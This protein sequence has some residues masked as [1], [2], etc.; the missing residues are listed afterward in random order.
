M[1]L[2]Q[3]INRILEPAGLHVGYRVRDE[4]AFYLTIHQQDE[5]ESIG[6]SKT[7]ALDFQL[8]QKILPRIQGS[9]MSVYQVLISLLNLLAGKQFTIDSEW[10][11]MQRAIEQSAVDYPRSVKK[12]MFML[13]RF[14]NDGFTSFWL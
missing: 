10:T 5:L 6:F 4:I 11:E 12:L 1:T 8:M 3:A 14:N 13:Q 2:L 7:A 9:S